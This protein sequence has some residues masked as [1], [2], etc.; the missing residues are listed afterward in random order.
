MV[1]SEAKCVQRIVRSEGHAAHSFRGGVRPSGKLLT[2]GAIQQTELRL[3]VLWGNAI[4]MP[5]EIDAGGRGRHAVDRPTHPEAAEAAHLVVEYL[6]LVFME[7]VSKERLRHTRFGQ[8]CEL[9]F[10]G[11]QQA[12]LV[13]D[14]EGR[15]VTEPAPPLGS[16]LPRLLPSLA[17]TCHSSMPD[18]QVLHDRH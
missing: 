5:S 12:I 9:V 16:C 6:H 3:G 14:G 15:E 18:F 8:N 10:A 7:R 1:T 17:H 11:R 4:T 13:R 2:R